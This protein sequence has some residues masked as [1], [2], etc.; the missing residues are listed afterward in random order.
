M[1]T[2][3]LPLG[4]SDFKEIRE[5]NLFFID[6]TSLICDLLAQKGTKVFLFTRPRRFGKSLALSMLSSFFDITKDSGKLFEGLEISEDRELC[7][8]WMNKFSR[9]LAD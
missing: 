6:K 4:E 3:N 2:V 8:K 7:K 9:M 5:Q 1:K